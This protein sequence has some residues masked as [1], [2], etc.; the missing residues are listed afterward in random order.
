MGELTCSSR[1]CKNKVEYHNNNE[2]SYYWES[3]AHTFFNSEECSKIGSITITK[4]MI[5]LNRN[6]L[7][8]IRSYVKDEHLVSKWS[9]A[10][11]QLK[12]FDSELKEI[13]DKLEDTLKS[14]KLKD[15]NSIEERSFKLKDILINNY[16]TI[17]KYVRGF[18][19]ILS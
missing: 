3:W 6:L 1:I 16:L 12:I 15:L 13:E 14:G 4:Q 19:I 10:L 8:K 2:D 9:Q 7:E 5:R 11:V 18:I 17:F